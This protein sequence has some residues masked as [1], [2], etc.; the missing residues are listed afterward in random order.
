VRTGGPAA[1]PLRS[2]TD[3]GTGS[4]SGN[5]AASR[6]AFPWSDTRLPKRKF[7]FS[8]NRVVDGQPL[9][10]IRS[11]AVVALTRAGYPV[12]LDAPAEIGPQL[13]SHPK[14]IP[15]SG[16]VVGE[17]GLHLDLVRRRK[18]LLK[19]FGSVALLVPGLAGPFL[20]GTPILALASLLPFSVGFFG[21]IWFGPQ[22]GTFDSEVAFVAY[23]AVVRST[24]DLG[25]PRPIAVTVGAAKV[26]SANWESKSGSG[27]SFK[28][29]LPDDTAS[30]GSTS[31]ILGDV[32]EPPS[33]VSRGP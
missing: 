18:A 9:A 28:T 29:F 32:L 11:R 33:D 2:G 14:G 6:M 5:P 25:N 31:G 4:S 13:R 19:T 1:A 17:R 22:Y 7:P 21:L 27:R 8:A 26:A 3:D 15:V 16:I 12:V 10:E 30:W 20:V 23:S 24:P